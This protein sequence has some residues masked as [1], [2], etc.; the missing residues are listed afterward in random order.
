MAR[1]RLNQQ[2]STQEAKPR[3]KKGPKPLGR[4]HQRRAVERAAKRERT[5]PRRRFS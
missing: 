3:K 2:R 1:G 4:Q 5:A